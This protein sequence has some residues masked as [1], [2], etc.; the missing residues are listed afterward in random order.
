[1][2]TPTHIRSLFASATFVAALLAAP[3]HAAVLDRVTISGKVQNIAET[4][5]GRPGYVELKTE[6]G[7]VVKIPRDAIDES[8]TQLR[9][10]Q[11]VQ[12]QVSLKRV[13]AFNA[14]AQKK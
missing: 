5:A 10:G 4:R 2:K 8:K 3:A 13:V 7:T 1:M 14:P 6:L 11:S 9:P 12:L